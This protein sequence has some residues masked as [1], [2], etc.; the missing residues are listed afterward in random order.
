MLP[1]TVCGSKCAAWPK[2]WVRAGG[3]VCGR[4]GAHLRIGAPMRMLRVRSC[5][6]LYQQRATAEVS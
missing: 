5:S 4:G 6:I 1:G 3:A 2:M